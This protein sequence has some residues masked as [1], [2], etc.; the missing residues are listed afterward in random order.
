ML[1]INCQVDNYISIRFAIV[2]IVDNTVSNTWQ[3]ILVISM[4]STYADR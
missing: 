4:V 3:I 1:Q 2:V